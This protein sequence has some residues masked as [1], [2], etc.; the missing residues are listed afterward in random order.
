MKQILILIT[1]A[2]VL[3]GCGGGG[4]GSTGGGSTPPPS[5]DVDMV[6]SKVYT[7]YPGDKVIK[8]SDPTS[9]RIAHTDFH[10]ESTVVLIEGSATIIRQ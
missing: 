3:V 10:D 9:I 5:S 1:T 2:I 7:V 8:T 4:S 6:I